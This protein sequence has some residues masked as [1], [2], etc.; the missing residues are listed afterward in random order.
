MKKYIISI[1]AFILLTTCLSAEKTKTSV[2]EILSDKQFNSIIENEKDMLLVF[3]LYA[4]WCKPCR[5]LSPMLEEIAAIN[6]N[7]VKIYKINVDKVQKTASSFGISSIPYVAFVKNQKLLYA[8]TGLQMKDTYQRA[9][10][11][12]N[13]SDEELQND[14]PSG[15]LKN[16]TRI[17]KLSKDINEFNIYV[18]SEETVK[19]ELEARDY[20]HSIHI[21]EYNISKDIKKNEKSEIKFKA[22]KVGIFPIYCNG[23]CPQGN[24]AKV[25]K[26]IVLSS[27]EENDAAFKTISAKEA[28]NMLDIKKVFLLD[29]RTP[30]EFYNEYIPGA[31]LIPL[32]QLEDRISEIEGYKNKNIILYC[33]SGNRS[34]VAA[35]ILVKKGFKKVHH[36]RNGIGEWKKE[37]FDIQQKE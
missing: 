31:K 37:S 29:V 34:A 5:M 17:V 11:Y 32:Q 6:K 7:K 13:E 3:D 1:F 9:I 22:K 19:L 26:I 23:K 25:G 4:D 21:P 30:N 27:K 36:I 2:I 33:R 15:E 18:Y 16:G 35:E 12:F 24:G 28:K 20:K 10:D 8:F 14:N